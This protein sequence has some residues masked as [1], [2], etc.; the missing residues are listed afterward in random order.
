MVTR[1]S[2]KLSMVEVGIDCDVNDMVE[3]VPL[4]LLGA[5]EASSDKDPERGLLLKPLLSVVS[6]V[7]PPS[8]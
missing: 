3:L 8:S 2:S 5:D 6:V 7:P 1:F 4:D